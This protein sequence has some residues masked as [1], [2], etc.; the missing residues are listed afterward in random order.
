[1]ASLQ[2][3]RMRNIFH[4]PKPWVRICKL[5]SWE[6]LALVDM[7]ANENSY[8]WVSGGK[9]IIENTETW[10]SSFSENPG[11][12]RESYDLGL[13]SRIHLSLAW[14]QD[15]FELGLASRTVWAWL[16]IK[17]I[18]SLAWHQ[19]L[20]ELGLISRIQ[21]DLGLA[22]RTVWAWLDIKNLQ[23]LAWYRESLAWYQELLSLVWHQNL[24]EIGLTWRINWAW[25]D[26]E[27]EN[28]FNLACHQESSELGLTL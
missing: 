4:Q 9:K 3:L 12:S 28:L 20:P 7:T 17:N 14:H 11:F 2:I 5:L 1:M 15:L 23:S 10:L 6:L 13:T 25:L 18:R 24:D 19:K 16:G 21:F 27:N 8:S 22:S 26:I